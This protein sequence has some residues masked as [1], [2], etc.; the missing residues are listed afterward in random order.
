LKLAAVG[1]FGIVLL[2]CSSSS[3]GPAATSPSAA[4]NV[5]ATPAADLRVQLDLLFGEQVMIV[6]KESAAAANHSDQYAAYTALL[7]TNSTDLADV[8]RRAL[9]NTTAAQFIQAWSI[10]NGYLVDYTI[11]VV[12]HNEDKANGAMS[13]LVNGYVPQFAQLLSGVGRLPLDAVTQLTTQQ[14]LEDKLFIDDVFAQKY[15]SFYADLHKAYAQTSRLGDALAA[16]IAQ[17]YPDKLPGDTAA[18]PVDV[19]VSFNV[20]LAEH[21]YLATM[22][23]DAVVAARNAEKTAAAAALAANAERLGTAFAGSFGSAAGRQFDTMWAARDTAVV[24]YASGEAVAKQAL[25]ETFVTAFAALA[26]IARSQAGNQVGATIKV[27][28]DQRAKS[29]KT[30]AGDDRAAATAMQPIA[31]SIQD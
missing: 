29:S 26:H 27:I 11:G 19:R 4:A 1:A 5:S 21:S 31:D 7:T 10:Q 12:T 24:G 16:Q 20:L 13:G 17:S 9:G 6:A 2:A 23:T 3:P 28:D 8:L 25:T 14:V 22:A 30:V 18:H 15:A